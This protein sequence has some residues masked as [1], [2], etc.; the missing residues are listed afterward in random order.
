MSTSPRFPT[1]I[2]EDPRNLA[3]TP[4]IFLVSAIADT[5]FP[6]RHLSLPDHPLTLRISDAMV[7]RF[8]SIRAAWEPAFAQVCQL[9][10]RDLSAACRRRYEKDFVAV[11]REEQ[12]AILRDLESGDIHAQH[13]DSVRPQKEAFQIIY[14]AVAAGAFADP[15]YGGN[16]NMIGWK[17]A[18]FIS[19]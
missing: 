6:P 7:D 15:A 17:Y 12:T 1:P 8:I 3:T 18:G 5:L 9:A 19:P 2:T 16:L 13:W 11:T 14:E 4:Y 10:L